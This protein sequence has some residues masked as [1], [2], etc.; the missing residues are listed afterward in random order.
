M[1]VCAHAVEVSEVNNGGE[2]WNSISATVRV[3]VRVRV[4]GHLEEHLNYPNATIALELLVLMQL[5][6]LAREDVEAL[7]GSDLRPRSE[8]G[9]SDGG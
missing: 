2:T 5:E 1:L 8:P 9:S 4:K 6:W 7:I 3:R